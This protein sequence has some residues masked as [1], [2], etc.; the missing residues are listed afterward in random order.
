MEDPKIRTFVVFYN[1]HGGEK[2]IEKMLR[3]LD[4]L[5][6]DICANQ[7]LNIQDS[8]VMRHDGGTIYRLH[9]ISRVVVYI[10]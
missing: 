10:P 5:V 9:Y 7:I 4:E 8:H 1:N 6:N 3:K 2:E